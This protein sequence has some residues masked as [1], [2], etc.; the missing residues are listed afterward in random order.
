MWFA[1]DERLF[2]LDNGT[3]SPPHPKQLSVFQH[4]ILTPYRKAPRPGFIPLVQC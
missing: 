3:P 1:E 4:E 2:L